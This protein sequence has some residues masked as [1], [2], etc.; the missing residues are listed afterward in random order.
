MKKL[1]LV[2]VSLVLFTAFAVNA[3]STNRMHFPLTG[4]SI[5]PLEAPLEKATQQS[6]MMFLPATGGF[7]PNVSVQI[8]PYDGSIKDY[9][10]LSLKQFESAGLK[11]IKPTEPKGSFVTFEYRG[12]ME[13]RTLHWYAKAEKT[14]GRVYLV[15]ATAPEEHWTTVAPQL[16]ACVD[17]FSCDAAIK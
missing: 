10:A 12:K 13:G 1:S 4:F 8:Q 17:S 16:K 3:E 9:S 14:K 11:V 2:I 6:I 7:A 15:T 5:A